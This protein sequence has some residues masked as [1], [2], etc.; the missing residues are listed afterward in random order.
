VNPPGDPAGF[1]RFLRPS[2]PEAAFLS[3]RHLSAL[4]N[5]FAVGE[6][7]YNLFQQI[8]KEYPAHLDKKDPGNIFHGGLA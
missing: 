7:P 2:R 1:A 4:N 3:G 6:I 5:H 8:K